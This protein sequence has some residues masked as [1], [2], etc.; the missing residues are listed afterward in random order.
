[1]ERGQKKKNNNHVGYIPWALISGTVPAY[2]PIF[3]F[4]S[5]E[6]PYDPSMKM[7][8]SNKTSANPT[9]FS[10]L[11]QN[12]TSWLRPFHPHRGNTFDLFKPSVQVFLSRHE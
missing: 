3:Q 5:N 11:P 12:L 8:A 4:F 2:S 6:G 9:E 7:P 10:S 1:M